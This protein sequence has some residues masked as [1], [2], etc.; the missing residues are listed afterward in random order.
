MSG[1]ANEVKTSKR[2][3]K[4]VKRDASDKRTALIVGGGPAGT[5][6][7]ETLR[8]NGFTGTSFKCKHLPLNGLIRI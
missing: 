6:C 2:T 4:M 1:D 5:T 8:Q 7:A 3:K